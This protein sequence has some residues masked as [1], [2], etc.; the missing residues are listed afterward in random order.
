[1][2]AK[3]VLAVAG[4]CA[5]MLAG[6]AGETILPC[7][8]AANYAENIAYACNTALRST[9]GDFFNPKGTLGGATPPRII[10]KLQY[11]PVGVQ[12]LL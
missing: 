4:D 2:A 8:V 7:S 10:V 12:K 11:E 5:I 1:M 9:G 3:S 6:P